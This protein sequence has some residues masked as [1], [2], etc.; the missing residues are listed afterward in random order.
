M[1]E[2]L[3]L[4]DVLSKLQ[5]E[6]ADRLASEEDKPK[7]MAVWIEA[8]GSLSKIFISALAPFHERGLV[9]YT[10]SNRVFESSDFGPYEIDTLVIHAGDR[11]L[12]L[13][14]KDGRV[15]ELVSNLSG[16]RARTTQ[17]TFGSLEHVQREWTYT[18]KDFQ[19][20]AANL[21]SSSEALSIVDEPAARLLIKRLLSQT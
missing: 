1:I 18:T 17:L 8:F 6:R 21:T 2:E 10:W 7:R 19:G 20:T 13:A 12:V 3:S 16:N 15:A 9:N 4:E 14:P 11:T 5:Q